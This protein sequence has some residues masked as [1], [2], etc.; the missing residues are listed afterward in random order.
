MARERS[1]RRDWLGAIWHLDREIAASSSR[2]GLALRGHAHRELAH[3]AQAVDDCEAALKAGDE[4]GTEEIR[5]DLAKG[6]VRRAGGAIAKARADALTPEAKAKIRAEADAELDRGGRIWSSLFD[7]HPARLD[8]RLGLVEGFL[9]YANSCLD[10]GRIE[11]AGRM[12]ETAILLLDGASNED[13]AT[14]EAVKA[15]LDA[16]F[17]HAD[18]LQK[19][20]RS[21]EAIGILEGVTTRTTGSDRRDARLRRAE[22]L[23]R[24]G[25]HGEALSAAK[26]V[27]LGMEYS[28]TDYY[29]AAVIAAVAARAARADGRLVAAERDRLSEEYAAWA[30]RILLKASLLTTRPDEVIA[31]IKKYPDLE[32]LADRDDFRRLIS[33]LQAP[34][35]PVPPR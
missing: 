30:V 16:D 4:D 20:D 19:L 6:L 34:S 12:E 3:W 5:A 27:T 14:A 24:L 9:V 22:I 7:S 13:K 21:R 35:T 31:R 29:R 17:N 11:E 10:S 28:L 2:D 26:S 8:Y 18:T 15:R 1:A 33:E 23:A 25:D 32:S